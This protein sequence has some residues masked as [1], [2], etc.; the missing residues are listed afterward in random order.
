M[1]KSFCNVLIL[2]VCC[3]H[4]ISGAVSSATDGLMPR[5]LFLGVELTKPVYFLYQDDQGSQ[6]ECHLTAG[7]PKWLPGITYG[8]VTSCWQDKRFDPLRRAKYTSQGQFFRITIDYNFLKYT[9]K[10]NAAFLGLRYVGCFFGDRLQ[11]TYREGGTDRFIES[12]QSDVKARWFE[13]TAGVRLQVY[14]KLY[15][16][17]SACYKFGLKVTQADHHV[18]YYV[19]GWGLNDNQNKWGIDTYVSLGVPISG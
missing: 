6:Y 16:G 1:W 7:Y 5:C 19:L 4:P 2:C 3:V 17:S 9:P 14:R 8:W 12:N 18:P 10:K 15:V 13:A 11:G